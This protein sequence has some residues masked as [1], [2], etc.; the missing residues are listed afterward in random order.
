MVGGRHPLL[1]DVRDEV[2]VR[3][4]TQ[5]HLRVV[6]EEVHLQTDGEVTSARCVHMVLSPTVGI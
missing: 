2:V 5:D 6:A 4:G 1:V 3:V